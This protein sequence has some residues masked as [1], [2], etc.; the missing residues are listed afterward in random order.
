MPQPKL[1]FQ[2][3]F[4][5]DQYISYVKLPK[6]I[7]TKSLYLHDFFLHSLTPTPQPSHHGSLWERDMEREK[8]Y[9]EQ[10]G[11]GKERGREIRKSKGREG[12]PQGGRRER[13]RE[14]A[15]GSG[16]EREIGRRRGVN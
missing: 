4:F 3:S 7:S 11:R 16:R 1:P 6:R 5:Y 12:N 2:H 13:E 8:G 14:L 10:V 9:R 15:E